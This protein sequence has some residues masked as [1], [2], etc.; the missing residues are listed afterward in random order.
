VLIGTRAGWS[1]S[2]AFDLNFSPGPGNEHTSSVAGKGNPDLR[3]VLNLARSFK[4][5]DVSAG[6]VRSIGTAL[7]AID[8]R[9]Q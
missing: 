9:F 8:K 6:S 1:V 5:D 2:P 3:D 4:I 7:A